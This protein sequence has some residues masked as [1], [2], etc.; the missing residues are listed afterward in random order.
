MK[1][2]CLIESKLVLLVL[3]LGMTL[4]LFAA[5]GQ[6]SVT[7]K[8]VA[9][10]LSRTSHM[11]FGMMMQKPGLLAGTV[12]LAPDGGCTNPDGYILL[13]LSV[14]RK[15]AGFRASGIPT[16]TFAIVLPSA[17]L[18][19]ISSTV[20]TDSMVVDGFTSNLPSGLGTLDSLGK[21]NISTGAT[22]HVGSNQAIGRY[23]GTFAVTAAYY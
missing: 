12:V 7:M 21:C 13:A 8:Y 15:T 17:P 22:L 5:P 18:S 4:P 1:N 3:L 16:S 20:P 11:E 10:T 19:I 2:K 6:A 23:T 9:L 14:T